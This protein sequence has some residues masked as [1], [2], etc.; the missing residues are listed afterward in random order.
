MR[1]FLLIGLLV[2]ALLTLS[3]CDRYDSSEDEKDDEKQTEMLGITIEELAMYD[4]TE[5]NPAYI[6]VDGVVYDVTGVSAWSSGSHNGGMVGTDV[7]SLIGSAPHGD[8]VLDDLDV[9]GN[10]VD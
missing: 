10:I 1:K 3:A 4:G 2:I 9:V 5:G 6:A 7:S 8:R